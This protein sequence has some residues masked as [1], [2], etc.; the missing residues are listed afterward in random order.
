MRV[1]GPGDVSV[2]NQSFHLLGVRGLYEEETCTDDEGMV[3]CGILSIAAL[4]E[5]TIGV[6]YHCALETFEDDPRT[7]GTCIPYDREARGPMEGTNSLN[8]EW[9]RS[10]WGL[11]DP[12]HTDAYV[13]DGAAAE[14]AGAGLWAW[15]PVARAR[16]EQV[17]GAARVIDGDTLLVAG[18]RVNLYGIQAPEIR[19]TCLRDVIQ[20]DCGV[21]AMVHLVRLTMG[22]TV[23][24]Q[25]QESGGD[26]RLFGECVA[27]DT[28]ETLSAQMVRDGWA[29]PDLDTGDAHREAMRLARSEHIGVW[30]GRF[31]LPWAWRR[32]ER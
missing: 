17:E 29:L 2:A 9:V 30:V 16:P 28:G 32:G 15:P 3:L 26:S 11:P 8:R 24:C 6:R 14:A 1:H 5:L 13:A 19:Q 23:R 21:R 27:D 7:W 4:A 31:V 20:Y 12:Q 22:R 10:G 25:R 18:T